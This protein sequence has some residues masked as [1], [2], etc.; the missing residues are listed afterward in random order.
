MPNRSTYIIA[1]ILILTTFFLAL[2]SI[3]EETFTFDETAH[4]GAGFSYLTKKDMR[5]N[6][7]HPPLIKNISAFPLLFLDLNFPGDHPSWT[8][9]EPP[10]WWFQFD[11][12]NQFLYHSGNNPDKILFWSRIPMILVLVFLAWFIFFWAKEMFG[13]KTALLSLFLFSF[14]P[15][16]LAH[17]RLVTTDIAAALGTVLATYFWLKFLKNPAKKNII[18]AGLIFG[19]T[20]L[21]KFSLILLVPFFALLTLVYIWIKPKEEL[22]LSKLNYLFLSLMVI[23]VGMVLIVFPVY[24]FH[25][26]NYPAQRQ[27]RDTQYLITNT[28]LPRLWQELNIWMANQPI[29]G[30]FSQYFLGLSLAINRSATGHTTYFLGEVSASGW[31]SYFPVVYLIKEPLP[32]H[33]LTLIALCYLAFKMKKLFWVNTFSRIKN[34]IKNNFSQ[35]AM[36][37][38]LGIYWLTSLTSELNI[39]V[40][41]L[42]PTFPFTFFLVSAA[43]IHLFNS[44]KPSIKPYALTILG[45]LLFWQAFSVFSIYPHFLAYANEV[46]GGPDN[47]HLYAVDSNLDWGQDLKRLKKWLDENKIDKIYLDYFGG[48]DTQYYLKE[49]FAPWWGTRNPEDLPQGSYLAVSISQLQGGR[50]KPVPGFDQPALYYTWLDQYTPIARIGYSIFVYRIIE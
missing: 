18:S 9:E 31:T 50:G 16:F 11:F 43:T 49:K 46:I 6:P 15:T 10:Q 21:F 39:G 23:I 2:F 8:Q 48:G 26:L 7:E 22:S 4:V 17:G 44:L 47:L 32:L 45:I 37:L 27:I 24:Q 20:M 28:S 12:A 41:H 19:L 14:S 38:F 5:L 25:T 40:R 29:L 35:F 3:Q 42:L 36:L 1:A 34:W 13:N 30:P 33:I